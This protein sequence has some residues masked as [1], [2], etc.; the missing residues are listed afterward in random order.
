[1]KSVEQM[2]DAQLERH[3][4]AILSR[5]LGPHGLA[6]FLRACRS[7]KGDYTAERHRWTGKT[8]VRNVAKAASS[9]RI[10]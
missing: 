1:M 9:R 4:L 2:T 6:R 5:E 10:P 3:A 8:T 7:G